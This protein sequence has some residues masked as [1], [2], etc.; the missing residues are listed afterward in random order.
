MSSVRVTIPRRAPEAL[1]QNKQFV[2]SRHLLTRSHQASFPNAASVSNRM[3]PRPLPS[4]RCQAL[5]VETNRADLACKC[6]RLRLGQLVGLHVEQAEL[7]LL[8]VPHHPLRDR[9]DE[10]AH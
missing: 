5:Q 6:L 7:E 3:P 1:L 2:E 9:A 4:I 8:H 10:F